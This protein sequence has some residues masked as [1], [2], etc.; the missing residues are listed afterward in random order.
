MYTCKI[1]GKSFEKKQSYAGHVS[2]HNRGESYKKNRRK[3]PLKENS[4]KCK[5]CE[6]EYESG[7]A[8]GGHTGSCIK[9]PT[10]HI[11]IEKTNK[12]FLGKKH[13]KET[14]KKMSKSMKKAH[15]EGRAWNIGQSRWNN[16]QS[17]PEKFFEQFLMNESIH[18][19]NEFSVGIY[20][21]DFMLKN[22]IAIEIDGKQHFEDLEV[23]ERD[24]RKNKKLKE[25]GYNLLRVKWTRL[26]NESKETLQE[27][28]EFIK[29]PSEYK[30]LY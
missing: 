7:I 23:I 10:R 1:C 4:H 2:S 30:E 18:Y 26:Y 13:S 17:W 24:K 27:I 16:E 19:E 21:V 15:R 6:K 25:E 9:N 5:Y 20:S 29:N 12:N 11:K 8:L 28:K 22:N 14:K 3:K